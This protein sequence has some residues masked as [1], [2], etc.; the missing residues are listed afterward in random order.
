M[1]LKVRH[2]SRINYFISP[3]PLLV[4]LPPYR[5][6][7]M[8]T[9]IADTITEGIGRHLSSNPPYCMVVAFVPIAHL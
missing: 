4:L 6:A 1:L 8:D 5:C 3:Q 7:P 9:I 2:F